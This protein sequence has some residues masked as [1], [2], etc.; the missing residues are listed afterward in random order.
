MPGTCQR[1]FEEG[2]VLVRMGETSRRQTIETRVAR[3][4]IP[5]RPAI[6]DRECERNG[7]GSI[8]PG[9]A[10]AEGLRVV[11]VADRRAAVDWT[12]FIRNLAD[13]HLPGERIAPAMDN[14]NTRRA[15]PLY[16]AFEPEEAIRL[17]GLLETHCAPNRGSRPGM[18]E[19]EI[20]VLSRQRLS[21]RISDREAMI[22]GTTA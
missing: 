20:G 5:G 12:H 11:K 9:F 6:V 21:R 15:A 8:F 16:E 18:G 7:A 4:A 13:D 10:P 19:I 1:E 3:P 17:R 2:E 22:R 14:L